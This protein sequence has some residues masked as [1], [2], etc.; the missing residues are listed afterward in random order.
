MKG[1]RE[2]EHQC[3]SVINWLYKLTANSA[4][5]LVLYTFVYDIYTAPFTL[6][7]NNDNGAGDS[8]LVN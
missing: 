4:Q 7:Y 3:T 2:G 1:R 8:Y 5:A 6:R